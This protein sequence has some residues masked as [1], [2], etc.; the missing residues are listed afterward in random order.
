MFCA[1]A[2]M[3]FLLCCG[4]W[5][6]VLSGGCVQG[7]RTFVAVEV[8]ADARAAIGGLVDRLRGRGGSVK[9]VRP[10]NLHVTLKFLGEITATQA[11]SVRTALPGVVAR[12][13]A[14]TLRVADTGGFPNLRRPRVLWVGL[15]DGGTALQELAA[16]VDGALSGVGFA[17]E[18]RPFAPHLTIG[19]VRSPRGLD[20]VTAALQAAPFDAAPF[21]VESVVFK[22]STLRPGG[23]EYSILASFPLGDRARDQRE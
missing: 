23:A 16:A 5:F 20:G 22:E 3:N 2:V 13:P 11:A 7:M 14:F 8:G 21:P 18:R 15:T 17:R 1:F 10:A 4:Q 12:C 19:R 6:W 9:W